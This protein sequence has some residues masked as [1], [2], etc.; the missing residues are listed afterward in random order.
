VCKALLLVENSS[1]SQARRI[2]CIE[3]LTLCETSC[4]TIILSDSRGAAA[5][6]PERD[7]QRE[8]EE[9]KERPKQRQ[10]AAWLGPAGGFG[11]HVS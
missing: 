8:D 2:G 4:C 6:Y 11:R 10:N 1:L 3:F 7:E 5:S 9:E